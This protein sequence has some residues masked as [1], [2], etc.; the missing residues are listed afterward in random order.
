LP[1][2]YEEKYGKKFNALSELKA[3]R[4][5]KERREREKQNKSGKKGS[6]HLSE[7][8]SGSD[9][10][11]LGKVGRNRTNLARRES[12]IFQNLILDQIMRSYSK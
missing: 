5:E 4:E 6:K 10:E 1:L 7:S 8:D 12:N 9:Y 11:K 3:K 2:G